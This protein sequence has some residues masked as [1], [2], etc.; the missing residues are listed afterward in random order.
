MWEPATTADPRSAPYLKI[1]GRTKELIIVGGVN[2]SP[3]EVESIYGDIPGIREVGAC[4]VADADLSEVVGLAVVTTP[5]ANEAEI[6]AAIAERGARLS[7]LKRPRWVIFVASLPRNALGKLQRGALR[8][9][10]M[11]SHPPEA[12]S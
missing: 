6:R 8:P 5:D 4:G 2:V 9:L 1:I 7:G 12:S 10:F 3:A 11:S